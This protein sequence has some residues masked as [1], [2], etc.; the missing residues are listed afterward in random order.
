MQPRKRARFSPWLQAVARLPHAGA[1][2]ALARGSELLNGRFVIERVLG[3]GGMGV[4]HQAWDRHAGQHVALKTLSHVSPAA[5]YRLKL[6]FRAAADVHHPNLVGMRELFEDDGRWC[7]VMEL[8][9]GETLA[10]SILQ[11]GLSVPARGT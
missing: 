6:E 10:R 3:S 7:L 2:V 11:R 5:I 1:P 4:V 8:L 9:L